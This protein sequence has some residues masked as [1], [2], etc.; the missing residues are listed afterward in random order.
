MSCVNGIVGNVVWC[1]FQ[2]KIDRTPYCDLSACV[3]LEVQYR[4]SSPLTKLPHCLP[5]SLSPLC[6]SPVLS[7]LLVWLWLFLQQS[8]ASPQWNQLTVQTNWPLRGKSF[9]F[10]ATCEQT[11]TL[12]D[13]YLIFVLPFYIS[14]FLIMLRHYVYKYWPRIKY[15]SEGF[16]LAIYL[17]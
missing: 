9:I 10:S 8:D 2:A 1:L 3:F 6:F 4:W 11:E 5:F 14:I 17:I 15:E 16:F 7:V 13:Y 12:F